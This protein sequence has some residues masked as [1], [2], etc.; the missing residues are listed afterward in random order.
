MAGDDSITFTLTPEI[1]VAQCTS[2]TG[3]RLTL[4]TP[5]DGITATPAPGSSQTIPFTVND[6]SGNT[7]TANVI[8]TRS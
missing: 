7:A 4:V 1:L 2:S 3:A 5:S 6:D 8:I